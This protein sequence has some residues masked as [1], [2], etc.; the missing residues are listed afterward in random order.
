MIIKSMS[1]S[2]PTFIQLID[3]IDREQEPT[4]TITNNFYFENK[5]HIKDEFLKN[6]EYIKYSK[7]KNYLYHEVIS[8]SK[9]DLSIKEQQEIIISLGRE[10]IN[11]RA[12]NCLVYGKIHIEKEHLHLHLCI[13]A[14][15]LMSEKR[16]SLSKKE[17]LNIQKEIESFKELNYSHLKEPSLYNKAL[18][19]EQSRK[20]QELKNRTKEP[21][22]K[23][24]I[25]EDLK[26]IFTHSKTKESLLERLQEANLKIYERGKTVGVISNLNGKHYRLKTLG[27]LEDY[28]RA[29]ENILTIEIKKKEFKQSREH[30]KD[31]NLEKGEK[32]EFISFEKLE[33]GKSIFDLFDLAFDIGKTPSKEISREQER[34]KEKDL[35]LTEKE[36]L[37]KQRKEELKQDRERQKQ[38]EKEQEQQQSLG[39]QRGR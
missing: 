21:S 4:L 20:E 31:L 26:Q 1:R 10:Y 22:R 8:L 36:L 3:Y 13:S 16:L 32:M 27:L 29:K 38:Q 12:S 24:I 19:R 33:V 18:D 37:I 39:I 2:E 35:K 6:S 15:E 7:G 30:S 28:Q 5:E 11:K 23:E 17:F 34:E 14:N 25:K 9:N